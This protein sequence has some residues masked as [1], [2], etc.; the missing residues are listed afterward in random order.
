MPASLGDNYLV[1]GLIEEVERIQLRG[2]R[3]TGRI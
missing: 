2:I 3:R 1:E